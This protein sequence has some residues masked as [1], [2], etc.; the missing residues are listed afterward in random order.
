MADGHGGPRTPRNPA[1][2]SGP[3]ALSQRT[4][5]VQSPSYIAGG[6]YGDGG[7]MEE[8]GGAAMVAAPAVQPVPL[9]AETQA[10]ARPI[11]DGVPVGPGL[12]ELPTPDDP[13]GEWV[14]NMAQY[15]PSLI[16]VANGPTSSAEF[17]TFVRD[18]KNRV[19]ERQGILG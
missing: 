11:T 7:L 3:G 12:N 1:P 19:A 15:L 9:S 10:P 16:A 5:G 18:I 4:D 2:V 8:Q 13:D 17:R 6:D 14:D